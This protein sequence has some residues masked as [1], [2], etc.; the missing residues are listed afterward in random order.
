MKITQE[1]ITLARAE[2]LLRL[3]TNNRPADPRKVAQYAKAMLAGE[4]VV[5]GDTIAISRENVL[6]NG[7][8]RLLAVIR[9]DYQ[10][11]AAVATGV[12]PE[13][14]ATYDRHYNRT[15]G[16]IFIMDKIPNGEAAATIASKLLLWENN[17]NGLLKGGG[18]A[19]DRPTPAELLH[20]YHAHAAD[21]QVAAAR[22]Q[23]YGRSASFLSRNDWG[24][25]L[26]LLQRTADG[27]RADEFLQS[28][29][30]GTNMREGDIALR[31][32]NALF[33]S[34]KSA[35]KLTLV[36][37]LNYVIFSWNCIQEGRPRHRSLPAPIAKLLTAI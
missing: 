33:N 26:L 16:Q 31:A 19:I 22:G 12:E 10:Y 11:E 1:I 8:H 3:N 6:L 27:D 4:W 37:K 36:A 17:R 23:H 9:A 13:A 7:Q 24:F 21:I 29:A 20:Y 32:R 25:L 28:F 18:H 15:T 30:S 35:S 14:F 2:E 34:L 5:N